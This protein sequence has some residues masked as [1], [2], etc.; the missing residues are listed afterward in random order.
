MLRLLKI[1]LMG[2]EHI[3]EIEK[4]YHNALYAKEGD[5]LPV[6]HTYTYVQRCKTCGKLKMF[7]V[8]MTQEVE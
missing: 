5:K 8:E 1:L 4:K 7:K 6:R 3:W 2:H